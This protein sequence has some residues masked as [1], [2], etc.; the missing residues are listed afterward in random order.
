[1][2]KF[3]FLHAFAYFVVVLFM[4][5]PVQGQT[6]SK[7]LSM[8][9]YSDLSEFWGSCRFDTDKMPTPIKSFYMSV[10]SLLY[11]VDS[12]FQP[13]DGSLFPEC[14]M[15]PMRYEN[16]E[17]WNDGR[18]ARGRELIYIK[19]QWHLIF[20]ERGQ[21]YERQVFDKDAIDDLIYEILRNF[22]LVRARDIVDDPAIKKKYKAVLDSDTP[23][24][25][26]KYKLAIK[27]MEAVKP[28]WMERLKAEAARTI[29]GVRL[30]STESL[31]NKRFDR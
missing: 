5:M 10:L 18:V 30:D 3:Q 8:I 11:K 21:E 2:T 7:E 16:Y 6:Q 26:Q 4:C 17:V 20:S 31:N 15:P 28:E 29:K 14:M 22:L 1:M 12:Q 19:E 25:D 13:P 27:M 23:L 9:K 24:G